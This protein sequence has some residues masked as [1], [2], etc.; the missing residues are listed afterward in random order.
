MGF[1]EPTP[2][3]R[4]AIPHILARRDAIIQAKTGSGKTLAYGLPLLSLLKPGPRPQAMVVVPT[5]ELA[6]Q[7]SEA[8]AKAGESCGL[9]VVALYGG[10]SLRQQRKAVQNGQDLIVGT[11]GRLKDLA[12]RDSLDLSAIRI[13]VL[14]EADRMVDMGFR[15]D[16]D[17]LLHETGGREQTLLL[18]ATMSP[19]VTRLVRKQMTNPARVTLAGAEEAPAELSHWYLRVPRKKRFA[20][21][22]SLLRAEKPERA[23]LFTE[24]KHETE[25]LA[26]WLE[27]KGDFK[28]GFLN[29]NMPQ[30]D[31]NKV[32][33]RFRQG[34]VTLLVA[35]DLAARGLDI[36]G[37][38]HV[39]HYSLPAVVDTYIHR[40]GRTARNGNVGKTIMLVVPEQEAEFEAIQRRIPC[41]AYPASPE[42]PGSDAPLS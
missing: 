2:V 9:R 6:V 27:Q 19:E 32:L 17:F 7:I 39:F 29:G 10:M 5:R 16:M 8:I 23:I 21:L 28:V 4:E 11:P 30:V 36:E 15:K 42:R 24:M 40:S 26:Q 41:V 13:L 37:L 1:T 20:R 33:S 22:V 34:E 31:R 14:D 25:H 12:E 38:S 3:Q 35:T 18:S